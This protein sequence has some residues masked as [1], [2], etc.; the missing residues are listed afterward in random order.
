MEKYSWLP[1]HIQ[2]KEDKNYITLTY[3]GASYGA[4]TLSKNVGEGEIR[5]AIGK[6]EKRINR[7][8]DR[9]MLDLGENGI[10]QKRAVYRKDRRGYD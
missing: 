1:R 8:G 5:K 4:I 7:I 9:R 10:R 2:I 3:K 6:L